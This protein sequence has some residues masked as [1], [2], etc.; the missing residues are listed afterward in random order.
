[1]KEFQQVVKTILDFYS[2]GISKD[3]LC[4]I[5][6]RLLRRLFNHLPEEFHEVLFFLM[7]SD[8]LIWSDKTTNDDILKLLND[9]VDKNGNV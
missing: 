5:N 9:F 3:E 2:D 6:Q 1:M 7:T 4:L 8:R